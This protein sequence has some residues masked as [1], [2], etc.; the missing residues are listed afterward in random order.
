[1]A[2]VGQATSPRRLCPET[3]MQVMMIHATT[4]TAK[5]SKLLNDS[6]FV[7]FFIVL[8]LY[9]FGPVSFSVFYVEAALWFIAI[10][11]LLKVSINT[12]KARASYEQAPDL[13]HD[14]IIIK[15]YTYLSAP[16][17]AAAAYYVYWLYGQGTSVNVVL[18]NTAGVR[19]ITAGS[20]ITKQI[21][22]IFAYQAYGYI[23][24]LLTKWR[25]RFPMYVN[26]LMAG[27]IV[28]M[29]L[30]VVLQAGRT[31]FL[32]AGAIGY[33]TFMVS[34]KVTKN[35]R[36]A[37]G[38]GRISNVLLYV[39]VGIAAILGA[40]A[41][42]LI[43]IQRVSSAEIANTLHTA[44][45]RYFGATLKRIA[46]DASYFF[47]VIFHYIAGPWSN[48]NIAIVSDTDIYRWS[49]GPFEAIAARFSDRTD[50]IL[51][52]ARA[53]NYKRYI[54]LGGQPTGWRT[55]FGNVL[56]WYGFL[57]MILYIIFIGYASGRLLV[58]ARSSQSLIALLKAV[59]TITFLLMCLFYFP[60][61]SIFWV[62]LVQIFLIIPLLVLLFGSKRQPV[63]SRHG[64]RLAP[65]PVLP[66]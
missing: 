49:A 55:G 1:M 44:D 48:F 63:R 10:L 16:I 46:P 2:H 29:A 22:A 19:E 31:F 17:S 61:D 51:S 54:M 34:S 12:G 57:G 43:G 3:E 14:R 66:R 47:T 27:A 5:K 4:R 37:K 65:R 60:S 30:A 35:D 26:A 40:V 52:G 50:L 58:K 9:F 36:S 25:H 33:A 23:P 38:K 64:H 32:V 15:Y 42:Y 45:Y 39:G 53:D 28:L 56:D 13:S 62:N 7:P 20:D 59:W 24:I 6:L 8:L 18:T 41:I 11:I 21:A